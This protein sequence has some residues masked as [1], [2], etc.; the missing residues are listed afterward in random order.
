MV[1]F[2]TEKG[3]F[4]Q[5]HF[6]KLSVLFAASS[7]VVTALA[8][9]VIESL[10][11][12]YHKPIT[13][14]SVKLDI[15]IQDSPHNKTKTKPN[16][17]LAAMNQPDLPS[18]EVSPPSQESHIDPSYFSFQVPN[19]ALPNWSPSELNFLAESRGPAHIRRAA[20]R[21]PKDAKRQRIEGT[22][23]LEYDINKRGKT[24]NIRVLEAVP[25]GVF[26]RAAIAA[27]R[28]WEYKPAVEAGRKVATNNFRNRINFKLDI[29]QADY[30][31]FR[32]DLN[33]GPPI[34]TDG[35]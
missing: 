9:G 13:Y 2:A 33:L 15:H 20:P 29:S 23:Y 8:L 14:K 6:L 10:V 32:P 21:Y 3:Q 22:V 35:W 30:Q 17:P 7:A 12:P 11:V 19:L 28:R 24:T 16:S 26:E 25:E 1:S 4:L 18:F 34:V 31:P 27:V 5:A